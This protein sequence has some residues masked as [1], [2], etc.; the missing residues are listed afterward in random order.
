VAGVAA[1]GALMT[2]SIPSFIDAI[3]LSPLRFQGGIAVFCDVFGSTTSTDFFSAVDAVLG[4]PISSFSSSNR[5][6]LDELLEI[7]RSSASKSASSAAP[8]RLPMKV[9]G[10]P[11]FMPIS[12]SL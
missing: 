5:L 12:S 10:R 2:I 7:A 4:E 1:A 6:L 11:D 8:P 3:F 9:L